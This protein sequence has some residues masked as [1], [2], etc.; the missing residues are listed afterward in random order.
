MISY[1]QKGSEDEGETFG[2][3]MVGICIT[4]HSSFIRTIDQPLLFNKPLRRVCC[5]ESVLRT[6]WLDVLDM[7]DRT[8]Y[9]SNPRTNSRD[10]PV[11]MDNGV[12]VPVCYRFPYSQRTL[13]V[14]DL[15]HASVK[16]TNNPLH[17]CGRSTA[18]GFR[19]FFGGHS[20][21]V[22]V[23]AVRTDMPRLMCLAFCLAYERMRI[24]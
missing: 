20:V 19:N 1:W 9:T 8:W 14:A 6:I 4:S 5:H 23:P 22:A 10:K 13:D 17:P 3:P 12:V 18:L 15:P 21:M 11:S 7:V 2:N 24:G 16:R